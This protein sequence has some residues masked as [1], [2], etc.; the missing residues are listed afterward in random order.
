MAKEDKKFILVFELPDDGKHVAVLS[1]R[2]EKTAR[3]HVGYWAGPPTIVSLTEVKDHA[4][5]DELV[6]AEVAKLREESP[7][8]P[9]ANDLYPDNPNRILTEQP[10]A[11]PQQ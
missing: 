8:R 10:P 11:P 3:Q 1:S 7:D 6:Q 2:D 5:I 4:R 9:L